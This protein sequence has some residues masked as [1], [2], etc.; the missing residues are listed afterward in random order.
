MKLREYEYIQTIAREQNI[1]RASERLFISQPAL[2]RFLKNVEDDLGTL[3]F[4]RIGKKMVLTPAGKIYVERAR[5]IIDLDFLMRNTIQEMDKRVDKLNICYP[6][7]RSRLM[8][9]SVFPVF[10]AS[11]KNTQIAVSV[12]SQSMIQDFLQNGKSELALGVVSAE[13]EKLF[14]SHRI[15]EEEMVLVVP[16][17]HPVIEKAEARDDCNFPFI[18]ARHIAK[19]SFVLPSPVLYS[20]R[21]AEKYFIDHGITPTVSMRMNLTGDVYQHIIEGNGIA[22]LP[23]VPL[24]AMDLEDDLAY[25]SLEDRTRMH[26]VALLCKKSHVLNPIERSLLEIIRHCYH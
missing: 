15:A 11:Y 13:Y 26:T 25:L 3:L 2:S 4:E 6:L 21:F 1:T 8:A 7:I 5:E 16:K 18:D 9:K 12:A 24:Q 10:H 17:G 20:G 14:C 19:E 22:M 23:S